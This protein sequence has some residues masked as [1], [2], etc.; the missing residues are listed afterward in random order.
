M[1]IPRRAHVITAALT[2]VILSS[3]GAASALAS[4]GSPTASTGNGRSSTATPIKHLVVIFDENVSFDHYFGTYPY[5]KPTPRVSRCS[6]PFPAHPPST[7]STPAHRG[8]PARPDRCSPITPTR[9]TRSG[10]AATQPMTCDQDHGYTAEQASR[11][12]R[13]RGPY[14]QNTGR[15]P[16]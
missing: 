13:R 3:A 2:A 15:E 11:R 1:G 10:S 8:R 9:R 5:A 12:P 14:P 6:P 7:A 4:P 16:R